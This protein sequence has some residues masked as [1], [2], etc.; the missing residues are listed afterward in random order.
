MAINLTHTTVAVG[1]NAGNGEIAKE[2]WNENHTL[3]M[4]TDRLLGRATAGSGAVEEITCTAAGRALLDDADA[5]A[6]RATLNV[7]EVLTGARTYYVRTDGSDSNTGL[8]NTSGGAFLTIGHAIGVA[9]RLNLNG[10]TLTISVGAGTFTGGIALQT[11]AG[12]FGPYQFVIEGAGTG[13]TTITSNNAYGGTVSAYTGGMGTIKNASITNS[14]ANGFAV[15]AWNGG[16]IEIDGVSL[17]G[18]STGCCI[19]SRGGG[20]KVTAASSF[21]IGANCDTCFYALEGGQISLN[22]I[23]ITY[24]T[25]TFTNTVVAESL[26]YVFHYNVTNSGTVTATR[27]SVNSNSVIQTYGGGATAIAGDVAGSAS[28]GGIYA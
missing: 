15:S 8:A 4:A 3:T 9:S 10:Y 7:G 22:G 2:E 23:T 12:L 13:S 28:T 18:G 19:Y 25:R 17:S 21:T 24:G 1:T 26:S 14:N 5:A 27:Y 6:Q 16:Q 20:S 11:V